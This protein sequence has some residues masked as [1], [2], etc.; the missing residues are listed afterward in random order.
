[1][2]Q[3]DDKGDAK[4]LSALMIFK[5]SKDIILFRV[6]ESLRMPTNII[7][8]ASESGYMDENVL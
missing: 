8:K 1:L 4:K 6:R 3:A 7:V 2:S 5:E